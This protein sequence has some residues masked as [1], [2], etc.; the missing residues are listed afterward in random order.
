MLGWTPLQ[1]VIFD[2]IPNWLPTSCK[3]FRYHSGSRLG[4]TYV[5]TTSDNVSKSEVTDVAV[6][7]GGITGLASAYYA[8]QRLPDSKIT[9]F[10]GSSRLG[11]WLRSQHVD[12]GNGKVVFEQGPR[13]LRPIRPNGWVTLDLVSIGRVRNASVAEGNYQVTS[14]G[15]E[16]QVIMTSKQSVA[17]QNRFI[18]YPDH[19]VRM[20]GPGSSILST[21][22]SVLQE[23]VFKGLISACL[24]EPTKDKVVLEDESIGSFIS[25]RLRPELA[26]NI[27]SALIH[28][29]YAGDIYQLSIRSIFPFL[30]HAEREKDCI[31]VAFLE[32]LRLRWPHDAPLEAQWAKLPPVSEKLQA[33]RDSSVFTFKRGIGQLADRLE[34]ELRELP[35]VDIRLQT[36]VDQLELERTD[37]SEKVNIATRPLYGTHGIGCLYS[38]RVDR[39]GNSIPP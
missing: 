31:A 22:L 24:S 26:D 10:E 8:A 15:L 5:T 21:I 16:D 38:R 36:A 9:L 32:G 4:R 3:A 2:A 25:R 27:V 17:A 13:N 19:L 29:I 6:L 33:I 7:G 14:L 39:T 34:T 23:P 11:G 1:R 18:Y 20:P 30:F 28:G 35:N 12:V 37:V